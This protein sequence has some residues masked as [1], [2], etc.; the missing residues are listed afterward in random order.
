VAT[1]LTV[2][3]MCERL[4]VSR[5]TYYRLVADGLI[6]KPVPV[7]PGSRNVRGLDS[8]VTEYIERQVAAARP[9]EDVPEA[10]AS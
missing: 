9:Q 6:K 7:R 5:A 3:Q 10:A 4:G 8:D 1:F 2:K